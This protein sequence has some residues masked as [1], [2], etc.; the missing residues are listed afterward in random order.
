M[1]GEQS[2]MPKSLR[3]CARWVR[4]AGVPS[5]LMHPD[6]GGQ[7]EIRQRPFLLWMHG[8]TAHKELDNSRYLRMIRAGMACVAIDLPGHGERSEPHMQ[9]S[10]RSMEVIEGM[11]NALP[12]MRDALA[13]HAGFDLARAAI[14]GM[15][16]GGMVALALPSL[17]PV[18]LRY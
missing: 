11:V 13:A 16:L 2:P 18:Y 14:G 1:A 8:R 6:Y 5:L 15:S 7:A 10:E 3:D 17:L 12:G 4:L 9:T